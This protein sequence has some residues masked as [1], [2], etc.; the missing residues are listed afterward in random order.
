MLEKYDKETIHQYLKLEETEKEN[1]HIFQH[2]KAKVYMTPEFHDKA[3]RNNLIGKLHYITKKVYA[4]LDAHGFPTNKK[5]TMLTTH[6]KNWSVHKRIKKEVFQ[7]E[8]IINGTIKSTIRSE[9]KFGKTFKNNPPDMLIHET[10]HHFLLNTKVETYYLGYPY[11]EEDKRDSKTLG[12]I[13]EG[14]TKKRSEAEKKRI[15]EAFSKVSE[16]YEKLTDCITHLICKELGFPTPDPKVYKI[17]ISE[18]L[19]KNPNYAA[20]FFEEKV[21]EMKAEGIIK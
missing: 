10:V 8:K 6:D 17:Y 9:T 7:V 2:G 5:S 15:M 11:L 18:D 13:K 19:K 1:Y 21:K 16:T 14:I 3:Q 20:K 12:S 4:F